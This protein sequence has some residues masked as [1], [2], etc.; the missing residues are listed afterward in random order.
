M[1][2]TTHRMASS[3]ESGVPSS[4]SQITK[5]PGCQQPSVYS[6]LKD[7]SQAFHLKGRSE[8]L[9]Q[10]TENRT[11]SRGRPM[12]RLHSLPARGRLRGRRLTAQSAWLARPKGYLQLCRHAGDREA[13]GVEEGHHSEAFKPKQ[14]SGCRPVH[15]RVYTL[16]LDT[17]PYD[18]RHGYHTRDDGAKPVAGC[19]SV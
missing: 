17:I 8:L 6:T 12:Q 18:C 2:S 1:C 7:E 19:D 11:R 3:A 13:V 16:R 9:S 4:A 10:T 15:V 14:S 5:L